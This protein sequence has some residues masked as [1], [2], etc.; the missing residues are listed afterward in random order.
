MPIPRTMYRNAPLQYWGRLL[1][2][3][4]SAAMLAWARQTVAAMAVLCV[5]VPVVSAATDQARTKIAV[6][7]ASSAEYGAAFTQFSQQLAARRAARKSLYPV[8]KQFAPQLGVTSILRY[9]EAEDAACHGAAHELGRVTAE[10]E[11]VLAD[12]MAVCGDGCTYGCVHGVFKAYFMKRGDEQTHAPH[13]QHQHGSGASA[14]GMMQA[15][16]AEVAA[17]CAKDS[18][19]VP[20]F[21]RGNCAH[22]VG[23]AFGGLAE[24]VKTAVQACRVFNEAEMQYYCETGVFM[25]RGAGIEHRLY[26]SDMGFSQRLQQGIAFCTEV[27]RMSS[28]CMRF[29]LPGFD[30]ISKSEKLNHACTTLTAPAARR[31]CYNAL[32]FFSRNYLSEQPQDVTRVCNQRDD[33]ERR[34]CVAGVALMKK[35][36]AVKD[37]LG[38]IC[39]ALGDASLRSLCNEQWQ[40]HYYQIGNPVLEAL[41]H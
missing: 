11:P 31:N 13:H 4:R 19:V 18:E 8:Y 7:A 14:P 21:F 35:D 5:D 17:V 10:H 9:L 41:L 22:S 27:S 3:L 16:R 37:D 6:G 39:A 26:S 28:A 25:E 24:D 30:S 40:R 29:V 15:I 12:A 1:V 36:H 34:A 32:G 2:A 33:S 23:H 38:A 20:D